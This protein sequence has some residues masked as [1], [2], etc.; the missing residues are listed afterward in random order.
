MVEH[1]VVNTSPLIYLSRA[2]L[3]HLLKAAE[4]VVPDEVVAELCAWPTADAAQKAVQ[5]CSWL[6]KVHGILVPPVVAVWDLGAG[7]SAVIAY[8]L[9]Q[10]GTIAVIDDLAARR[11]ARSL[12][13]PIRGTLGL[14]LDAKRQG[15]IPS[16][17]ETLKHLR[18]AVMYLSDRFADAALHEV[19]E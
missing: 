18:E 14:V 1:R 10:Q 17:R 13:I 2:G 7:E 12:G 11:C 4:V 16:A 9:V 15:L 8:A 3:L 5:S 19:G 6:Q